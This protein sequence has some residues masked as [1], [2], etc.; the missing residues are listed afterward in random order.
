[1]TVSHENQSYIAF[2]S[3]SVIS[4]QIIECGIQQGPSFIGGLA[5]TVAAQLC[6]C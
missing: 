5:A 3:T 4:S 1:M 2:K 6:S